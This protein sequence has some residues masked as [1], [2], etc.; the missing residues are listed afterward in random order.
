MNDN[1]FSKV[2]LYEHNARSYRKIKEAYESGEKIVGIVHA[3]GTGKSYNALQLAYDNPDKKILW[4]VP[5]NSIS[6]YI[7]SII[8][9][10]PNLDRERDFKNIE[11]RTYQSFINMSKQE[12]SELNCDLLILDEFH[13]I[14]APVWGAR[15]NTLVE[16]HPEMLVFGMTAYTVIGRG[17]PYERDMADPDTNEL[18]SNKIVSRY[19]L[20]DAMLD[21]VLP[22]D[23]I[24][25]T[26]YTNLLGLEQALE[27]KINNMKATKEELEQYKR[28]LETIKKRVAE[29][30]G[31]TEVVR[32]YVKQNGKYFYFCPPRSEEGTNDINTIMKEAYEWFKTYVPEEDIVFY[33]TTSEMK[34]EGKHNREMFYNDKTLDGQDASNKLRVMFAINQYNEGVHAPNVDGVIMGRGTTS[35]IVYFEQL[36]RALSV[37]GNTKEIYAGYDKY[38]YEELLEIA[39]NKEITIS[40]NISREE[41]IE[42][43]I[44]PVLIDL[45]NNI[46]FIKEL[47]DN[48]KDRVRERREKSTITKNTS[49]LMNVSFDIDV[50]NEDLYKVLSSLKNRVNNDWYS[51]YELAKNYYEHYG[52]LDISNSFRTFNGID[53]SE[54]GFNLGN[55]Y[56]K[57]KQLIKK[58]KLSED[59]INKLRE[60]G[61]NEEL[62]KGYVKEMLSNDFDYMYNLLE[63]YYNHYKNLNIPTNFKTINGIDYDEDGIN[64]YEWFKQQMELFKKNKLSKTNREKFTQDWIKLELE[65]EIL[66]DYVLHNWNAMY[67][68]LQKY[69]E[70]HRNVDVPLE[71]RTFNGYEENP[72]GYELGFWVNYQKIKEKNI[73]DNRYAKL[74]EL[75][76]IFSKEDS[77]WE[78]SYNLATKYFE[79]HQDLD[80]STDFRTLDGI[81]YST[82]E[83]AINLYDW[84]LEQIEALKYNQYNKYRIEKLENIGIAF[85]KQ[86]EYN[87]DKIYQIAKEFY[88]TYGH[89]DVRF[90][91]L[92]NSHKKETIDEYILDFWVLMCKD[93]YRKGKLDE[94]TIKKLNEIGMFLSAHE[95]KWNHMY[96][97]ACNYLEH[98]G[99]LYVP[100]NFNTE[101][102]YEYAD[103]GYEL[104]KW[105]AYQRNKYSSGKLDE[106]RIDKLNSINMVWDIRNNKQDNIKVCLEYGI[107]YKRFGKTLSHISNI[108]LVA[109]INYLLSIG[110]N[111]V[112]THN[113]GAHEIFTMSSIDMKNKYG[114][115]LEELI[116]EYY[117]VDKKN[118][119]I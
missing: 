103:K 16:T 59:R 75:N 62:L 42:K 91:Q 28:I 108:E 111:I 37:G 17:T 8:R 98:W 95:V 18:F 23:I 69:Y 72:K 61:L 66:S 97:L 114:Y 56:R 32:K 25:R 6:E 112:Y 54:D 89:L 119:G 86:E 80:I 60:I 55:W 50:V 109:K 41:L 105:I 93:R 118:R 2:G 27:N 70:H 113:Y 83:E 117:I 79:H 96:K 21:G 30:P 49:Q 110:E 81:N 71:F 13:H 58:G 1:E 5:N 3:T 116:N 44:A 84:K 102:G 20:V 76:M 39:K 14:G 45:T 35:D 65:N 87:F 94:E 46:E 63:I 99:N 31:I 12:I 90:K 51:M 38:T 24:Y 115:T 104:G 92:Y 19:D 33:S 52:N 9:D 22:R 15:I 36:G 73:G 82:D 53:Y 64:L 106:D 101:N 107:D 68:L 47:E 48:I 67:H 29:A 40:D 11:F 26:S 4:I 85:N 57:Q 43:I 34:E 10:N 100:L 74:K 88:D 78:K 77:I 7:E